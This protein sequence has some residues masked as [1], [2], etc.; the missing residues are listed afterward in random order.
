MFELIIHPSCSNFLEGRGVLPETLGGELRSASK[1]HP[2]TICDQNLRF[3][4]LYLRRAVV[5]G[6]LDND[7]KVAP[8]KKH[9]QFKTGV[10]KPYPIYNQNIM[11]KIDTLIMTKT[12][13]K[14]YPLW[15]HMHIPAHIREY[16][17]LVTTVSVLTEF[18]C[19]SDTII[20]QHVQ[21]L[22]V[23]RQRFRHPSLSEKAPSCHSVSLQPENQLRKSRGPCKM[24]TMAT[25]V[26]LSLQMKRLR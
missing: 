19:V 26:D 2:Y 20:F 9:T 1:K 25:K 14:Q 18:D 24:E 10:Q 21:L 23:S 13:K 5:D 4:T 3:S 15:P 22:L 8:F 12:A 6:L 7:E 16:L 17:R 11:A